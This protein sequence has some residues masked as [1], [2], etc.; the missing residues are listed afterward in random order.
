MRRHTFAI[1][2]ML[3]VAALLFG[4]TQSS[5]WADDSDDDPFK[6]GS[7][8]PFGDDSKDPF[9]ASG[10]EDPFGSQ[11]K[12]PS[13]KP[14]PKWPV[15][16]DGKKV[17]ANT[18]L[19]K[20]PPRATKKGTPARPPKVSAGGPIDAKANEAKIREVLDEDTTLALQETPLYEVA[21]FLKDFHGIEIQFDRKALNE[22]DIEPDAPITLVLKGRTLRSALRHM[23]KPLDLSFIIRDEVLLITTPE[24]AENHIIT[25]V[26]D[27]QNLVG[28]EMID[29]AAAPMSHEQRLAFDRDSDYGSIINVIVACVAPSSWP[30]GTGPPGGIGIFL[31]SRNSGITQGYP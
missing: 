25:Q 10:S 4:L 30:E 16:D 24:V 28:L 31:R 1:L 21:K 3:A 18:R 19:P 6:S 13:S 12:E 8:D 2:F 17:P 29:D 15:E 5:V 26:Y 14:L 9:K 27:V 20:W 7:S 23:L 22:A 11:E